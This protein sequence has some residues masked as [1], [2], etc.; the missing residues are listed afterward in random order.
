MKLKNRNFITMDEWKR[1]ELEFLIG[2]AMKL[3]KIGYKS[4]PLKDKIIA[5]VFFNPSLRTR[6]SLQAG[7]YKLGALAIDLSIGQGVWE[8]EH[9]E[10]IIMDGKAAEHVKDAAQVLSKYCDA[11]A[12]RKFPD[13]KNW[14]EDKKDAVIN[15]FAKYSDVP[16]INL[17]G[18]MEH[19]CQA[20]ADMMT[21]KEHFKN[22]KRKKLLLA[23]TYHP[24]SLPMAVPNSIA[25]ASS[26]FGMDVSIAFP[27]E[28]KLDSSV[29]KKIKD[30]CL[31]NKSNLEIFNN[32]EDAYKNADV[33]YAKSWGSINFYGNPEQEMKLK[34]NL[35]TWI[36]DSKKMKLTNNAKFMHCLPIRR[37]IEATDGVID[38]KDSIIYQQAENRMHTQNSL[39]TELIS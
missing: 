15:G 23:W 12:V 20:L 2:N 5:M 4:K 14:G 1:E 30:N 33:I 7:I 6:T 21:I 19:P 9:K 29:L 26:K 34:Q 3:K 27:P 22:L 39:L 25:L 31:L 11:I 35:K 38:G 10:G 13:M 18:A 24:K 32:Q 17:E 36:V 16:V 28:F 8:L 37:N